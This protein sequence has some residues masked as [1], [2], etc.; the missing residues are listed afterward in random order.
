MLKTIGVL[1]I[2]SSVSGFFLMVLLCLPWAIF[3]GDYKNET[4]LLHRVAPGESLH[5]I[6]RRYL[7]LTEAY[8]TTAL[9]RKIQ[10]LNDIPGTLIRVD[11][12]LRIPTVRS[13]PTVSIRTPKPKDFEARGIYVNRYSMACRKMTRLHREFTNLRGNTV[14]LDGKDM[15]GR[16]SYPSKVQLAQTIGATSDPLIDDPA[17]LFHHLQQKGLHVGVRL[18]LFYD[19]LLAKKRP[20]LAVHSTSTGGLWREKGKIV[21]VDPSQPTVQRYNLDI[22]KELAQMG[23]DEIQFDYVRFPAMGNVQDAA[24]SFDQEKIPKHQIITSFLSLAYKDLAPYRILLSI[25]VFG[26]AAWGRPE[27]VHITGQKIE[28]LA[29]YCD[30]IS[31]M[32]YPSHFYGPF[33][34]IAN[35]GDHPF[36]FVSE[37]CQRT[38]ALLRG[39]E[40]TLRPWIQAFPYGTTDFDEAYVLEEL[41]ALHYTRA[42]GWLLWSAGNAYNTAWKALA[43][44][45]PQ[46]SSQ[47]IPE[48]QSFSRIEGTASRERPLRTFSGSIS[49]HRSQEKT[50]NCHGILNPA[51]PDHGKSLV[52][53]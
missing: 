31:P 38:S 9:I 23:V 14:I 6:A 52:H 42:R 39:T 28:D 49:P 43:L 36:L 7:P 44:W 20:D 13:T 26:I 29:R 8:T 53:R 18:V 19:P 48:N 11:Q 2:G 47:E 22:A 33:Q 16:L 34:S 4:T 46:P 10:E 1:R 21:W 32:I 25:D 37:T 5:K 35:P 40:V 45:N 41:R 24:Y 51:V 30:V 27:D 12:Y 50:D 15:S 3:A 17:K